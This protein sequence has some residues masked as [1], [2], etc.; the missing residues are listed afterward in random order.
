MYLSKLQQYILLEL[1]F[2]R[3]K[4]YPKNDL[5]SYY[6]R[7]NKKLKE[8]NKQSIITRSIERLIK[9]GLLVGYGER[10]PEKWYIQE[11]KLTKKGKEVVKELLKN[12]GRLPFKIKRKKNK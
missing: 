6:Q 7:Q 4:K 3:R 5:K 8:K 1:Y 12:Y 10:T 11:I 9:K 2:S